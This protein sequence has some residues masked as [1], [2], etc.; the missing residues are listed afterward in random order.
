MDFKN[1]NNLVTKI[2]EIQN[3]IEPDQQNFQFSGLSKHKKMNMLFKTK[4]FGNLPETKINKTL[5]YL[6][7]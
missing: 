6:R 2:K 7:K 4:N 3:N 1:M 5:D